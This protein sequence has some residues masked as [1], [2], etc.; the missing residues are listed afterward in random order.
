MH[1]GDKPFEH[2]LRS[3]AATGVT[4]RGRGSSAAGPR[5]AG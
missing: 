3:P 1:L 5:A 4:G 2:P